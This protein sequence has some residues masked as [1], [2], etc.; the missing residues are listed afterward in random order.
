M[1]LY[2]VLTLG[3]TVDRVRKIGARE[4]QLHPQV[5]LSIALIYYTQLFNMGQLATFSTIFMAEN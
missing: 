4:E 2:W 3:Q 5:Y 1:H